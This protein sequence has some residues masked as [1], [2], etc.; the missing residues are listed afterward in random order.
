MIVMVVVIATIVMDMVEIDATIVTDKV[1]TDVINVEVLAHVVN[2]ADQV[3][4]D[5]RSAVAKALWKRWNH[6]S[7][8]ITGIHALI[9]MEKDM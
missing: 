7:M 4:C 5:A 3:K 2:V 6:G 8:N 1:V 9:A